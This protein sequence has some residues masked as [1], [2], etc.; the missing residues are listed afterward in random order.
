M[1]LKPDQD[2]ASPLMT[3]SCILYRMLARSG[4]ALPLFHLCGQHADRSDTYR[5]LVGILRNLNAQMLSA[6]PQCVINEAFDNVFID[7][8]KLYKIS[9]LCHW[10][11]ILLINSKRQAV[12]VLID[13]FSLIEE[14]IPLDQ[15]QVFIHKLAGIIN[16]LNARKQ[17][18]PSI[19]VLKVLFTNSCATK[20]VDEGLKDYV[21]D[22][23]D[24][25]E[26]MDL[27]EDCSF[28]LLK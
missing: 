2:P 11:H 20:H 23:A 21:L 9:A 4:G 24:N 28:H 25:D 26:N 19:P 17:T 1:D 13:G 7:H 10:L 12:F 27:Y 22:L 5:G 16:D 8:L 3:V 18:I 6:D 14:D 15:L